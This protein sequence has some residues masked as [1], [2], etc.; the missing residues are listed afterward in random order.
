MSLERETPALGPARTRALAIL[1]GPRPSLHHLRGTAHYGASRSVRRLHRY[2]G[3]VRLLEDV[4]AGRTASAFTRRPVAN[5][6][7]RRLR[8]LPVL[9][10]G[11]SRRAWGLRLRRADQHLALSLLVVWPSAVGTTSAP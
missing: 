10:H 3:E 1:L 4:H 9:V 7:F 8:G 5:V 11:V 6:R 2:Y